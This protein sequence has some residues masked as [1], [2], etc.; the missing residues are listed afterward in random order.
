[1][2]KKE[3]NKSSSFQAFKA[4][5]ISN[6]DSDFISHVIN[7]LKE[8][9]LEL[10]DL[11]SRFSESFAKQGGIT[12]ILNNI[13]ETIANLSRRQLKKMPVLRLLK[14]IVKNLEVLINRLDT[15]LGGGTAQNPS[16]EIE[17]LLVE[18]KRLCG[19]DDNKSSPDKSMKQTP[20]KEISLTISQRE[21]AKNANSSEFLAEI[22][23][24]CQRKEFLPKTLFFSYAWPKKNKFGEQWTENFIKTLAIQL[25]ASGLEVIIDKQQSGLGIELEDFMRNGIY[26]ADHVLVFPTRTM[27]DK[28]KNDG[29]SGVCFEKAIYLERYRKNRKKLSRFIMP[30]L[31]NKENNCDGFLKIFAEVSFYRNGYITAFLEIITKV[32]DLGEEAQTYLR[33]LAIKLGLIDHSTEEQDRH[34]SHDSEGS[35]SQRISK[36]IESSQ[37]E[38]S[39]PLIWNISRPNSHFTGRERKLHKLSKRFEAT[40]G[41]ATKQIQIVGP[42]G[43]GKTQTVKKFAIENKHLYHIIYRFDAKGDMYLQ[44]KQFAEIINNHLNL[45]V[46]ISTENVKFD[47]LLYEANEALR[48]CQYNWLLIFENVTPTQQFDNNIPQ[49][50]SA[51]RGHILVTSRKTRWN[52]SSLL[53]LKPFT[54]EEG[55]TYI[56]KVFL[57]VD[58]ENARKLAQLLNSPLA[59][60]QALAFLK[61]YPDTTI[62]EYCEL[63]RK[64]KSDLWKLEE[65]LHEGK[66]AG[67]KEQLPPYDEY[68][69]TLKVTLNLSINEI[70]NNKLALEL[71]Y[72]WSLLHFERVPIFFLKAFSS[73]RKY[74]D[75]FDFKPAFSELTEN[76]FVETMQKETE[77]NLFS[78]HE[79]VQEVVGVITREL[80]ENHAI[81]FSEILIV[82][83]EQFNYNKYRRESFENS[84]TLFSHAEK[85][86]AYARDFCKEKHDLIQAAHLYGKIRDYYLYYLGNY[87]SA[88]EKADEAI[89]ILSK[90]YENKKENNEVKLLL[91]NAIHGKGCVLRRLE[92]FSEARELFKSAL[93]IKVEC[94]G[95]KENIDA[96]KTLHSVADMDDSLQN[97]AE[98]LEGFKECLGIQKKYY[99]PGH[100]NY[101]LNGV[102]LHGI[103][104]VYFNTKRYDKAK[105]A[106]KKAVKIKRVAYKDKP[107]HPDLAVILRA[108]AVSLIYLGK[109]KQG[110]GQ[111][112]IALKLFSKAFDLLKE[113]LQIQEN[114]YT[115]KRHPQIADTHCRFAE[116]CIEQGDLEEAK[117]HYEEATAIYQIALEKNHP[118]RKRCEL[119]LQQLEGQI[120]S[121]KKM[122][123]M[124]CL[125]NP[126]DEP[127]SPGYSSRA[128]NPNLTQR[129]SDNRANFFSNSSSSTSFPTTNQEETHSQTDSQK[130]P[131][132]SIKKSTA[133]TDITVI[134]LGGSVKVKS[135]QAQKGNINVLSA[136]SNVSKEKIDAAKDCF[137]VP[138]LKKAGEDSKISHAMTVAKEFGSKAESTAVPDFPTD[139][140]AIVIKNNYSRNGINVTIINIIDGLHVI[141]AVSMN[142]E[143]REYEINWWNV[144]I[145]NSNY[146]DRSIYLI[147]LHEYFFSPQRKSSFSMAVC[148]GLGG[149][150]KTYIVLEYLYQHLD[151]YKNIFWFCAKDEKTLKESYLRLARAL[152]I[153]ETDNY[154]QTIAML[155][156]WINNHPRCLLIFD[157]VLQ[158]DDIVNYLPNLE[159]DVIC[160]SRCSKWQQGAVFSIEISPFYPEQCKEYISKVLENR[161]IDTDEQINLLA[162]KLDYFP[163]ACAQA[164]AFIHKNKISIRRYLFLYEHYPIVMLSDSNLPVDYHGQSAFSL[165]DDTLATIA[166]QSPLA[167]KLLYLCSYLHETN[168]PCLFLKTFAELLGNQNLE[169]IEAQGLLSCYCFIEIDI[170]QNTISVS[171]FV[172][173]VIGFKLSD[174]IVD[175]CQ[176]V[177][178]VLSEILQSGS[179]L[180]EFYKISRPM[181]LQHL[182]ACALRIVVQKETMKLPLEKEINLEKCLKVVKKILT[183]FSEE[184]EA[185]QRRKI[186]QPE[187]GVLNTNQEKGK[188]KEEKGKEKEKDDEKRHEKSFLAETPLLTHPA[189]QPEQK[190]RFEAMS[191]FPMTPDVLRFT[192]EIMIAN[193]HAGG[194]INTLVINRTNKLYVHKPESVI[195]DEKKT[196]LTKFW[197]VP[198]RNPHF[199][200]REKL[201][202][203]LAERLHP[204]TSDKEKA[205][206]MA[207][208]Y[209][210][211]GA[212]KTQLGIE[213]IYLYYH[214]YEMVCFI[215]ATTVEQIKH[216]YVE[217]ARDLD[218]ISEAATLEETIHALKTWFL[219]HPRCLLFFDDVSHYSAVEWAL[220]QTGNFIL[221]TS[222]FTEWPD[223][224]IEVGVFSLEEAREYLQKI[225]INRIDSEE[226]LNKLA[227]TVG[228][229]PLALAQAAAYIKYNSLAIS[230]YLALYEER[231]AYLLSKMELPSSDHHSAV[232]VTWDITLEAI[233]KESALSPHLLTLCSYLNSEGIPKSLL[234]DFSN[235][236]GNNPQHELFDNAMGILNS[237]SLISINEL[238]NAVSMHLMIQTIFLEKQTAKDQKEWLEDIANLYTQGRS[239][240]LKTKDVNLNLLSHIAKL[241]ALADQL[242]F[243]TVPI[244]RLCL[245]RDSALF[246]GGEELTQEELQLASKIENERERWRYQAIAYERL[247]AYLQLTDPVRSLQ[248]LM[249]ALKLRQQL[250]GTAITYEIVASHCSLGVTYY[251]QNEMEQAISYFGNTLQ[252]IDQADE[253][254]VIYLSRYLE[255]CSLGLFEGLKI[256]GDQEGYNKWFQFCLELNAKIQSIISNEFSKDINFGNNN[257]PWIAALQGSELEH[258]NSIQLYKRCY[259]LVL[260]RAQSVGYPARRT[261]TKLIPPRGEDVNHKLRTIFDTNIALVPNLFNVLG[262]FLRPQIATLQESDD[263]EESEFWQTYIKM[264]ETALPFFKDLQFPTEH[265]SNQNRTQLLEF[266]QKFMQSGVEFSQAFQQRLGTHA[267][268]IAPQEPN[269]TPNFLDMLLGRVNDSMHRVA[270]SVRELPEKVKENKSEFKDTSELGYDNEIVRR[271]EEAVKKIFVAKDE[272]KQSLKELAAFEGKNDHF[273]ILVEIFDRGFGPLQQSI[274]MSPLTDTSLL[275]LQKAKELD[276]DDFQIQM[277]DCRAAY[278]EFFR[279][280]T[281]LKEQREIRVRE[282]IR[283]CA[284]CKNSLSTQSIGKEEANLKFSSAIA[285]FSQQLQPLD[286]VIVSLEKMLQGMQVWSY[287]IEHIPNLS[288]IDLENFCERYAVDNEPKSFVLDNEVSMHCGLTLKKI[289]Y[290]MDMLLEHLDN[291][292]QHVVLGKK[293]VLGSDDII[294]LLKFYKNMF[295]EFDIE[296][297]EF[298]GLSFK[299]LLHSHEDSLDVEAREVVQSMEQFN[300]FLEEKIN[301]IKIYRKRIVWLFLPEALHLMEQYKSQKES[302][303][304][305]QAKKIHQTVQL[306]DAL[307]FH[308]KE[309][310]KYFNILFYILLHA[311]SIQSLNDYLPQ[312]EPSKNKENRLKIELTRLYDKQGIFS[313]HDKELLSKAEQTKE[314]AL[315]ICHCIDLAR[316]QQDIVEIIKNLQILHEINP[317]HYVYSSLG[318]YYYLQAK[319]DLQ[320]NPE[321][322]A[323]Q[324][325]KAETMHQK[326]LKIMPCLGN[327]VSYAEF[328]CLQ[329]RHNE[330]IYYLLMIF[331]FR[332]NGESEKLRI[333]TMSRWLLDTELQKMVEGRKELIFE[334]IIF[335]YYLF[336][337]CCHLLGYSEI[338]MFVLDFVAEATR[339]DDYVSYF[340]L[341]QSCYLINNREMAILYDAKA[342]EKLGDLLAGENNLELALVHYEKSVS[343]IPDFV[344]YTKLARL[345]HHFRKDYLLAEQYFQKAFA[346][347]QTAV[348]SCNYALLLLNQNKVADAMA[349]LMAVI[350]MEEDSSVTYGSLEKEHLDNYLQ[351]EVTNNVN[352]SLNVKTVVIAYYW[353]INCYHQ[354]GNLAEQ[355]DTLNAFRAWVEANQKPLYYR[356]LS[357]ACISIGE[358]EEAEIYSGLAL[359]LELAATPQQKNSDGDKP[360]RLS[361]HERI[362][363]A[364]NQYLFFC[365]K[366]MDPDISI[367]NRIMTY[368]YRNK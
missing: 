3:K 280:V 230:T 160:I 41:F 224:G 165:W 256:I 243:V 204:S 84:H 147:Q 20:E 178:E 279:I 78:M 248:S 332:G 129:Q 96:A 101:Q 188:E 194:D 221:T 152:G 66:K 135:T 227:N 229:L 69:L 28:I 85:I 105:R 138:Q 260:K 80:I 313:E 207:S 271:Y 9:R 114:N 250:Y 43:I 90:I 278:G 276:P 32:Y 73:H 50:H 143:R 213:Y 155:K 212:G 167:L 319:K 363:V 102:T 366:K 284:E 258:A 315:E 265:T 193:N 337:K 302:P 146:I 306:F 133:G 205:M 269:E 234:E 68:H 161:V 288:R 215:P 42:G 15:S 4:E 60:T 328:L 22:L 1:M 2:F 159:V 171:P 202:E 270:D 346:I 352:N 172:Q 272:F 63:F 293:V 323:K 292:K 322:M 359:S 108:H 154:K 115:N 312:N 184:L 62:P 220:P 354:W 180:F 173:H 301:L 83:N 283:I 179:T 235:I 217:L 58:E 342:D 331:T 37:E 214:K 151:T 360:S 311:P 76:S 219:N 206:V 169:W 199:T 187:P 134:S 267:R 57:Q 333:D 87:S 273:A 94:Y 40:S 12:N 294:N 239:E 356:I 111:S 350:S 232:Y 113:T 347:N 38:N 320:E 318:F 299:L 122:S 145:R 195:A 345:H 266:M 6:I 344:V 236:E 153:A 257:H 325:K 125:W 14:Q 18:G 198:P 46:K 11:E 104:N 93:N 201:L 7:Y 317:D 367:Q 27:A 349:V 218:I 124:H 307:L 70:K 139:S 255:I 112:K 295:I 128:K 305:Q 324:L 262:G 95:T 277:A 5:N 117:Q 241:L 136:E 335:G 289:L 321:E 251:M 55:M 26:Q 176:L 252:M 144:P 249:S 326:S 170:E 314:R 166:H 327:T 131:K 164:C 209:G 34:V 259:F 130:M 71:L 92:K 72:L 10:A 304:Y 109:E 358:E 158:Y 30:I 91:A 365:N 127:Q 132:V 65:R 142:T 334:A 99:P 240:V 123:P 140:A 98:A 303:S 282:I 247:G 222:R 353:L 150:G 192:P 245:M 77:E 36:S 185:L 107:N 110:L 343:L 141:K 177:I 61:K 281:E 355:E 297:P 31:L 233:Q 300:V 242:G 163:L 348:L 89:S 23:D 24:Y 285:L 339:A 29:L 186:V 225:L 51:S 287:I 216:A 106:Y 208:C 79:S 253:N 86:S 75:L 97:Y 182:E 116:L 33:D 191:N 137:P 82:L 274:F 118:E 183:D 103:G 64:R 341:A 291:V 119:A 59:L 44:Y 361:D 156:G 168:I 309:M 181:V 149:T 175:Y 286:R 298:L 210:M 120:S 52:N 174:D 244:I 200:G 246:G 362:E 25:R 330:A 268:Q 81:L 290:S 190:S 39:F 21:F 189:I 238:T 340:M 148:Y 197:N 237:Y 264:I 121:I 74:D 56:K 48:T 308:F 296:H 45:K 310:R 223:N 49:Q 88:L 16:T 8:L 47:T 368:Y 228:C 254:I 35:M 162:K 364:L 231:K 54:L 263:S 13:D 203:L 211:G 226:L 157:E 19:Y 336:I 261:S 338:E 357:Y 275:M 351:Q 126:F 196:Y 316:E 100:K 53:K 67:E 329:G 17:L